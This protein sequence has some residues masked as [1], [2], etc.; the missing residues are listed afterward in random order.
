MTE[1]S[2]RRVSERAIAAAHQMLDWV[3]R[4]QCAACG[5]PAT[6]LCAACQASLVELGPA[7][8]RCAEPVGED[9]V[10]GAAGGRAIACRRCAIAPLPL[11]RVV[12]PWRFGGQ[13]AQ[14]IR[15]LK[16][17][18]HAHVARDVAPLWAP[19]LAAVVAAQDAIVVPVPLHWRRRWRRGYDH[20]WL[21]AEHAC[22]AM[23]IAA[24]VSALRRVRHAPPQSR[25]PA[26]ERAANVRGA[27]VARLPVAGRAVVLVD[28][29]MTTGATL[30]AA[31]RALHGAGA[32]SVTALVLARATLPRG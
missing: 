17:A 24:P 22:A 12:A 5:A 16:F 26:S 3:F 21:L 8:P 6:T 27:F 7:C 30:A 32:S 18:N 28:D 10:A 9:R 19:A 29:V 14:A 15:R 11:D 25:L 2:T 20:A 23:A 31:A 1:G 13:L 4:P